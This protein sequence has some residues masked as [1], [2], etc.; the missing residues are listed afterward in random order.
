MAAAGT[1]DSVAPFGPKTAWVWD[2]VVHPLIGAPIEKMEVDLIKNYL[3]GIHGRGRMLDVG[4]GGGETAVAVAALFPELQVVGLDLSPDLVRRATARGRVFG[5]RVRFVAGSALELPFDDDSFD[6]VTSFGSLKFWPDP[7]KGLRECVRVLRPG[8][9]LV[10]VEADRGCKLDDA[11]A[12]LQDLRVP[13]LLEPL[14]VAAIRT[15]GAGIS[16]TTDEA[17]AMA[18]SLPLVDV[19][20]TPVPGKPVLAIKAR[21]VT[22]G[23]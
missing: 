13:G 4:C 1:K 10:V 9:H 12:F 5:D 6:L 17:R 21:K 3:T 16:V 18:A 2:R 14:L 11:K 19:E 8:G 15:W 22:G 23:H 7:A 20:V